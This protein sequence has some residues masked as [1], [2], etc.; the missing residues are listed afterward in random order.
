MR[1]IHNGGSGTL[2]SP[3]ITVRQHFAAVTFLFRV[4][5]IRAL[6]KDKSL[7]RESWTLGTQ[8][9]PPTLC[10]L[11]SVPFPALR[12]LCRFHRAHPPRLPMCSPGRLELQ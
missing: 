5:R 6:V 4:P 7:G 9:P 12:S 8:E 10:G 11:E 3:R 2:A 1:N